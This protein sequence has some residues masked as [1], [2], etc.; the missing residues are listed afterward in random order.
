MIDEKDKNKPKEEDI[1]LL[2]LWN[3][4]MEILHKKTGIRGVY[5]IFILIISIIL[6]FYG[7]MNNLIITLSATA[8]PVFH[9]IKSIE[10][11]TNDDKTW[12]SYWIVYA[13]F[14]IFDIF[15]DILEKVIPLYFLLKIIFLLWC[16]LP[17]FG[18]S[19]ILY[20]LLI[21]R[22]FLKYQK[23]IEITA[24]SI[25]REIINGKRKNN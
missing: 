14:I 18:G 22:F 6:I 11:K 1:S 23:N 21:S 10:N 16:Y 15:S 24:Y 12:L 17:N 4:Q 13:L 8:Y 19:L 7:I 20:N 5:I 9:T 2:M 3:E 25:K